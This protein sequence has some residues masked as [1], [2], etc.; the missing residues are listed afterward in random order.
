VALRLPM[1]SQI[2]EQHCGARPSARETP[3]QI[4]ARVRWLSHGTT[5]IGR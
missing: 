4:G 1:P 5:S 2:L 3:G